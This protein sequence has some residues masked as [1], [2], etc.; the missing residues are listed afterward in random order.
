MFAMFEDVKQN[1][2]HRIIIHHK[3]TKNTRFTAIWWQHKD[4]YIIKTTCSFVDL[5]L[6]NC[7]QTARMWESIGF[8]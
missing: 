7:N 5:Q 1:T 8:Y 2:K 4:R 3:Q 6:F